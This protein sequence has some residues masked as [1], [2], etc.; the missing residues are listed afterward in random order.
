MRPF[1]RRHLSGE[2]R[3]TIEWN[4]VNKR[5]KR[6]DRRELDYVPAQHLA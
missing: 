6:S 2:S 1:R 3:N 5:P 4:D